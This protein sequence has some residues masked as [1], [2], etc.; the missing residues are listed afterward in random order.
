MG[1]E[2]AEDKGAKIGAGGQQ[3]ASYCPSEQQVHTFTIT[4]DVLEEDV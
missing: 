3:S 2:S 4:L 1:I